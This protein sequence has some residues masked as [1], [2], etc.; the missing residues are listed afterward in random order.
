MLNDV[1]NTAV[2]IDIKDKDVDMTFMLA[3]LSVIRQVPDLKQYTRLEYVYRYYRVLEIS[4]SKQ[5]MHYQNL[6]ILN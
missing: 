6:K 2:S 4:L 3:D 5:K 1:D